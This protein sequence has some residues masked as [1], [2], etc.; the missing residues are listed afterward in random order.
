MNLED[1][2]RA[3]FPALV[4]TL[5]SVLIALAFSDLVE[6]AR[7]RMTL[8]PLNIGTLRTWGQIFAMGSCAFSVWVIFAHLGVSRLRI[9]SLADSVVVF[10]IPLAILLGNSLTGL[11]E[12]W[13]WFYFASFYLLISLLTWRWQVHIALAESELSSFARL[14]HPM[15]PLAVIYVGIPFYAAAGYADSHGFL[16]P[17]VET[18]IA[19]SAS[20]VAWFTAWLFVREWHQAIALA[21]SAGA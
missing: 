5:L 1:R 7:A 15:G 8:W 4:V 16:P 19:M 11:K 21:Q 9:P 3:Q 20:P 6:L 14:T 18:L 12:I 2:I 13:P 10:I 17:L